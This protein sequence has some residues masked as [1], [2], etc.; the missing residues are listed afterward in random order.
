LQEVKYK[1]LTKRLVS[2]FGLDIQPGSF[3][4]KDADEIRVGL[5][6]AFFRS[7]GAGISL[8]TGGW[9]EPAH[10]VEYRGSSYFYAPYFQPGTSRT[11]IT[12]G[13][14][15]VGKSWQLDA[16]VDYA[17]NSTIASI[18]FVRPF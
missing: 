2:D 4:T 8:R 13:V 1:K 15:F 5:E 10:S 7:S 6:K 3:Q 18:S 11:H 16:G 17:R 12:G 9:Y 14:G